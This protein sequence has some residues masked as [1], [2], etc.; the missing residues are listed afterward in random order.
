MSQPAAF[1]GAGLQ[2]EP[3]KQRTAAWLFRNGIVLALLVE[4]LVFAAL[5]DKFLT[6]NNLRLVLLQSAVIGLLAVPVALL[7]MSGYIDFAMGSMVGLCGAAIG[8]LFSL[9]WPVW[10]VLLAAIALGLAIGALEG[11]LVTWLAFPAII[12]TLGFYT[13]L[14]GVTYL[15][16]DGGTRSGFPEAFVE[17]GQ[18]TTFGL[19]NPIWFAAL[20]FAV[21]WV[22]H[23]RTKWGRHIV[24]LGDNPD[25]ASRSG[26]SK[27]WLPF[28][29]YSAIGV[30]AALGGV[31]ATARL[32][33]ATPTLG[34]GL[35]IAVLSA[36]LLGG[37][38]FG[39]GK[40]TI[41]GVFA[42]VLFIGFL[43]NGLIMMGASPFWVR[44]SAGVALVVAAGLSA[45]GAYVERRRLG[46]SS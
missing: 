2:K 40:G 16:G 39:G 8:A 15:V 26:I 7:L 36:V 3:L 27:K 10:L 46:T 23:A 31:I 20:A 30:C 18:G 21:G 45:L 4:V 43:N 38:S 29:L 25:A 17:I 44:V 33:S 32:D 12:V 24:A 34:E 11:V 6:S 13:G 35:E 1:V 9:D 22:V 41:I 19:P 37:V 14:R 42:G 5:S 28:W